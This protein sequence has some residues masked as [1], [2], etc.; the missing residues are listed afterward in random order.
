MINIKDKSKCSGC[1]ACASV[2][3]VKCISMKADAEGFSYPCADASLCIGCGCCIDVCPYN[4]ETAPVPVSAYAVR[5]GLEAS[6]SS[7]GALASIASA[8]IESGGC[9]F[10]AAFDESMA[11]CHIKADSDEALLRLRK[12]KYVQSELNDTFRHVREELDKGQKVLFIG[13]PCQT[14]GL[15]SFIGTDN[16]LVTVQLAC[17]G[18]PSPGLWKAYLAAFEQKLGKK[19]SSVDFR[20]KSA[21]WKSYRVAYGLENGVNRVPFDKD[22]Y[23]LA[24]LQNLSLRPSCYQCRFRGRAN[25]DLTVGDLWNISETLPGHDDGKGISLLTV[26][27]EKGQNVLEQIQDTV[28]DMMCVSVDIVKATSRNSGFAADIPQPKNRAVFYADLQYGGD[29]LAHMEKF[30]TRRS[31]VGKLYASLHRILSRIKKSMTE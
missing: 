2:C 20:D 10:G 21:G 4:G 14:A 22:T 3:P 17:H 1:T 23:M 6:S 13:T 29:V 28:K 15:N 11:V 18:V 7:G 16:S 26:N 24:Y 8:W 27:T 19:I 30:I 9:V 31:K 12:S 25:A 5:T